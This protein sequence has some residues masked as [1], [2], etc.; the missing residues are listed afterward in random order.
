M[1][2]DSG[3]DHHAPLNQ[4]FCL[5]KPSPQLEPPIKDTPYATVLCFLYSPN[6]PGSDLA[7]LTRKESYESERF[8][9]WNRSLA[10]GKQ[11]SS[12]HACVFFGGDSRFFGS[13]LKVW[14]NNITIG[15]C[16]NLGKVCKE[17]KSIIMDFSSYSIV[18]STT[19]RSLRP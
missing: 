14:P 3:V 12:A 13:L 9:I 17:E 11:S 5:H 2:E 15:I 7:T 6:P 16:G 19:T 10:E 8:D 18:P 4:I 1:R